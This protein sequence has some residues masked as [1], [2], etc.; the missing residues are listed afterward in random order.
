MPTLDQIKLLA[1]ALLAAAALAGA[2][3][4]GWAVHGYIHG[5]EL[6]AVEQQRDAA[7]AQ[8]KVLAASVETCSA[9]VTAAKAIGQAAINQGAEL[10]RLARRGAPDVADKVGRLEEALK[11]M[12]GSCDAAWQQIEQIEGRAQ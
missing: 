6:A 3:W 10:L 11:G 12:K 4:L 1:G 9:G 2:G 8:G 7:I 5:K